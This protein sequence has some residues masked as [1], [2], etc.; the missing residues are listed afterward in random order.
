[1]LF[2]VVLCA[3]LQQQACRMTTELNVDVQMAAISVEIQKTR[4]LLQC[5]GAFARG[6]LAIETQA[7]LHLP[8]H[9]LAVTLLGESERGDFADQFI[10]VELVAHYI[11]S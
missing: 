4:L 10:E 7:A 2:C 8:R 11:Y 6:K 9:A 1:M 5:I 3:S